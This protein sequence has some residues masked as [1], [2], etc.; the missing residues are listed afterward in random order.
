MPGSPSKTVLSEA[1]WPAE[2]ASL[3]I[4]RVLLVAAGI[5][6]LAIAAKIKV[7][8]WPVPITM[9]T[10]VVLSIGAAYGMRLGGVTMLGYLAVGALGYDVFTNSSATENGLAYMGG[11]TGGYL[12]GFLLATL[13]LGALA[14]R[15]WDRSA[16]RMAG[17]MVIGLAIVYV[18]GVLWLGHL[19][20]AENGWAKVL[21]WGFLNFVP[22]EVL[23]LGLAAL[24][25]PT[26]WRFAGAARS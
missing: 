3:T 20:A 1:L 12:L 22:A 5:A 17:A 11:V 10:F 14:R 19:L 16:I 21:E 8:F 6:A 23:K 26:L 25:F 15:G 9:Q 4:K 24:L 2:G 18:P 13:A 7:P